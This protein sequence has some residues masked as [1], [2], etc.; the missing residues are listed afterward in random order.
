MS[1]RPVFEK[2]LPLLLLVLIHH[3]TE[4]IEE[5]RLNLRL[6]ND[7]RVVVGGIPSDL[8]L[9][10]MRSHLLKAEVE[11][12]LRTTG[13]NVSEES[14]NRLEVG[15]AG[16]RARNDGFYVFSLRVKL[17]QPMVPL[18]VA[19][20]IGSLRGNPE[21]LE[22]HTVLSY[23]WDRGATGYFRLYS[24]PSQ[25]IREALFQKVN[26]FVEDF[27]MAKQEEMVSSAVEG[28]LFGEGE[29]TTPTPSSSR[30]ADGVQLISIRNEGAAI[31]V[32]DA[33]GNV[34]HKTALQPEASRRTSGTRPSL[35]DS[36]SRL[37]AGAV[38]TLP[39]P[40]IR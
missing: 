35:V 1:A 6:V 28:S 23:T 3:S 2:C 14:E 13:I 38:S 25:S 8:Q 4:A 26:E 27:R 30:T 19:K 31:V 10:R 18:S 24:D 9:D 20:E 5:E 7:V 34:I 11:S 15:I 21:P 22:R 36:L 17:A 37:G 33:S 16:I 29:E 12:I 39:L 40:P 32:Y